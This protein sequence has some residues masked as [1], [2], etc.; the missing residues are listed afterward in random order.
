MCSNNPSNPA[1]KFRDEPRQREAV[2]DA[3]RMRLGLRGPMRACETADKSDNPRVFYCRPG[4]A[5][6]VKNSGEAEAMRASGIRAD[7]RYPKIQFMARPLC[8]PSH[9][10]II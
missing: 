7:F 3:S 4:G 6:I 8:F 2:G 9:V 10:L 5:K 1:I